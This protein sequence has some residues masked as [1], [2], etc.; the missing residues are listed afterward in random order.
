[1]K[2]LLIVAGE[3]SADRYAGQLIHAL[4]RR[5]THGELQIFGM[6]GPSMQKAGASLVSDFSG[7][8]HIGPA[9]A[10]AS[11]RQYWKMFKLIQE[12]A[13]NR[14]PAAAVLM[15]FPDF[16]LP[17]AKKL[18]RTGIPV[19]YYIGPQVWAWRKSR[20]QSIARFVDRM[21]VIFP[22]EADFYRSHG[23]NV[24]FVGHPLIEQMPKG[25]VRGSLRSRLHLEPGCQ[26]VTLFPGSRSKEVSH[27]LPTML[28]A[29][30]RTS[31]SRRCHF[32]IVKASGIDQ[33]QLLS[34]IARFSASHPEA[35]ESLALD[36]VE[37]D[38]W[39]A[40]ADSDAA[41]V[42]SGTAT[43]QAALAG[44]PFVMV[45]KISPLSWL[46]GKFLVRTSYYCIVNLIAGKK[47]V[48][49]LMQSDAVPE[50][51]SG[52]LISLLSSQDR[53]TAM[54]AE[55]EMVRQRLGNR[56]ASDSVASIVAERIGLNSG[57]A[58]SPFT[59]S[60]SQYVH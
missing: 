3:P 27:I 52:E 20:V 2:S 6:G 10:A 56:S 29:A 13:K 14:Q 18:K 36:L 35:A 22:F 55:F 16:N 38:P 43:L 26:L 60:I 44:V 53:R 32:V 48:P 51:I 37:C 15:D 41:I 57:S 11:L 25:I 31:Q 59:G 17:L 39:E 28:E 30:F 45:Y 46:V 58:E 7:L 21:L 4:R 9:A 1:M 50:R 5:D 33:D 34:F 47:V 19:L 8:S 12:A 24:E 42:K 54:C 23:V 49:E 40:L